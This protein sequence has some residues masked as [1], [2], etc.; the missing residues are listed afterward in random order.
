MRALLV[1]LLL[2][3]YGI[4]A[5][6]KKDAD[7]HYLTGAYKLEAI[8][9]TSWHNLP[10]VCDT[11]M[12]M[13]ETV[14]GLLEIHCEGKC[15]IEEVSSCFEADSWRTFTWFH[16]NNTYLKIIGGTNICVWNCCYHQW[17]TGYYQNNVIKIY[18][19]KYIRK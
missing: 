7:C 1:I 3:L 17:D 5:C 14:E 9:D 11:G 2:F 13:T 4:S 12:N 18:D 16:V 6:K 15:T 10:Y 8:Y 19:R